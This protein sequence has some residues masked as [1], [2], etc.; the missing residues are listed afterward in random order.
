M[1]TTDNTPETYTPY[2]NLSLCSNSV[3]GGGNILTLG[4]VI[5]LLVGKGEKPLIWLQAPTGKD[6]FALIIEASISKHPAVKV[7]AEDESLS[8]HLGNKL[9]LHIK[10]SSPDYAEVDEIDLRPLGINLFGNSRQ[11]EAGGMK[12]SNNTF[13]NVGTMISFG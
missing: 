7:L 11:L 13:R 10:S 8:V 2:P 6:E 5:P 4:K 12:L 3:V 1:I 9:I